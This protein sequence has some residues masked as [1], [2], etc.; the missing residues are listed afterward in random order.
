M[1]SLS[2]GNPLPDQKII[3]ILPFPNLT[4]QSLQVTDEDK[5]PID[6]E[7]GR[8]F[9][10]LSVFEYKKPLQKEFQIQFTV[11]EQQ[12][13]TL[14]FDFS[15]RLEEGSDEIEV[16]WGPWILH[17]G[18]SYT[19]SIHLDSQQNIKELNESD[20]L[21]ELN[22]NIEGD[23]PP[24]WDLI[25][26]EEGKRLLGDGTNV[27]VGSMDDALDFKHPLLTGGDSL[28][29]PRLINLNQNNSGLDNSPINSEHATQVMGIVLA[30]AIR[31]GD[32]EGMAPDARYVCTEFLNR[33]G[34]SD[35]EVLDVRDAAGFLVENGA[36]VINLSWSY[37]T[38]NTESSYAGETELTNLLID[39]LAYAHNIVCVPAINQL[40]NHNFPTAPGSSRNTITV[41]GIAS[42]LQRTWEF[43]NHGPTKD[44][45]SKPDL[46]GGSAEDVVSLSH[47]WR[48]G[49]YLKSGL[50][51]TSYCAPFVT[52]AVA[53]MIDFA[54]TRNQNRDHRVIKAILLSSATPLLRSDGSEWNTAEGTTLDAEQGAGLLN[55]VRVHQIYSAGEQNPNRCRIPGYDFAEILGHSNPDSSIDLN[56][57]GIKVYNLGQLFH[58]SPEFVATL[59]WDRHTFWND[60]NGNDMIDKEDS[61]STDHKDRLDNLDLLLFKDGELVAQSRSMNDNTE[62]LRLTNLEPGHYQL[63]VERKLILDSGEGE[64]YGLAWF[65][66]GTWAHEAIRFTRGDVNADGKF[67]IS[68]PLYTLLYLFKGSLPVTCLDS[69]DFNDDGFVD[70][71]DAVSNLMFQFRGLGQLPPPGRDTCGLDPTTDSL[72]CHQFPP[73]EDLDAL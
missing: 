63:V 39:Y 32:F 19:A 47:R 5:N 1:P 18:G 17:R 30:K 53:Q 48:E 9:W 52:G 56:S 25:R 4:V 67:D 29:R 57:Q 16:F 40:Q 72:D 7:A 71:S 60:E 36:E 10:L 6:L 26:S 33:S 34:P 50:F 64:E 28:G 45:R 69:A 49:E 51:G 58:T 62:H 38:G 8:A 15:R 68:D 42:N 59:T 3:D 20:N 43:Q 37:W 70:I 54:K 41:G 27:I 2:V 46:L 24:I 12:R 55:M 22:L 35:H 44:G 66:T 73:C 14:P 65:S 61:F 13:E 11:N 23:L 31:R 21:F